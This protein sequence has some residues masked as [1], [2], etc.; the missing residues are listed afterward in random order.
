[1]QKHWTWIQERPLSKV[2]FSS[3]SHSLIMRSESLCRVSQCLGTGLF[4]L[5]QRVHQPRLIVR[6]LQNFRAGVR[7]G[8]WL[9]RGLRGS[10]RSHKSLGLLASVRL[11]SG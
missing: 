8:I 3:H 5:A 10:W 7:G 9:H 6:Q 2:R 4:H 1:M 11:R